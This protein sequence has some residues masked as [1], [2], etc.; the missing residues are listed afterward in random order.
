MFA[1]G[2]T[3][4][5]LLLPL[6]AWAPDRPR[7][8]GTRSSSAHTG[9]APTIAIPHAPPSGQGQGA[10]WRVKAHS[11]KIDDAD[12]LTPLIL[13]E[14][15]IDADLDDS[16]STPGSGSCDDGTLIAQTLDP[17]DGWPTPHVRNGP[18]SGRSP[19]FLSLCHLR[20]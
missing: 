17:G 2:L 14:R 11:K 15:E 9:G 7:P 16:P 12:D 10:R 1:R 8:A 3:I 20:C 6:V 19:R 18:V 4:V 13:E 5:I